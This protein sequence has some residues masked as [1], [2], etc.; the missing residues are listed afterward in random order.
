MSPAWPAS[1]EGAEWLYK[2][3]GFDA[4]LEAAAF[5]RLADLDLDACRAVFRSLVDKLDFSLVG[6]HRE[7]VLLLMDILLKV[8]RRIHRPTSDDATY[9]AHRVALLEQFAAYEDGEEARRAFLPALDRLLASLSPQGRSS[10]PLVQRARAVIDQSYSRRTSLSSVAAR[11]HVSANYLSR[12]F[13]R[14]MGM[15]LTAY[16]HRVRLEH[17]RMLLAE[18]ERSISE[19]AYVVGY[20]NYRDFYRNF[21]RYENASP[22]TVQ[23]KLAAP[24]RG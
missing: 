8:S 13:R 1:A 9:H 22:R 7:A 15:T 10:H 4:G 24:T 21:V 17:A 23:R 6:R 20:Q 3:I 2:R 16:V 18:A 11:L 12:I 19:I 5:R 14:E